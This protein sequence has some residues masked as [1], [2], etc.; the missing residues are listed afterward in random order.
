MV[1]FRGPSSLKKQ[2]F[3]LTRADSPINEISNLDSNLMKL[4]G[5][6]PQD[7]F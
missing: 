7:A 1:K 2:S 6:L 4:F 5:L 3:K